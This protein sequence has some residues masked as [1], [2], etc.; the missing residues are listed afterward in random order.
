LPGYTPPAPPDEHATKRAL[1]EAASRVSAWRGKSADF[2]GKIAD[3]V[4]RAG[5]IA[6]KAE[7]QYC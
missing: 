3:Q 1:D 5:A 2:Q 7:Q 6:D 4:K